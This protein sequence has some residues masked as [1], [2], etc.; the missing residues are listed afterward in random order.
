M[1]TSAPSLEEAKKIANELVSAKLAACVN[2]IPKVISVFEWEGKIDNSDEF[3]LMIKVSYCLQLKKQLSFTV[4]SS[5]S[6]S[7]F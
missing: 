5:S 4:F 6:S 7:F 1:Y 3:L 2:I